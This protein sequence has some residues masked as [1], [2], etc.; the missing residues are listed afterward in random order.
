MQRKTRRM[1]RAIYLVLYS[2]SR[3]GAKKSYS[4]EVNKMRRCISH[5]YLCF[6]CD[7]TKISSHD[8]AIWKSGHIDKSG[9]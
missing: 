5:P 6:P 8:G 3:V 4:V 9:Y 2:F 7:F 1:G